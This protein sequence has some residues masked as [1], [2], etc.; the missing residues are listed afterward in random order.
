M[1]EIYGRRFFVDTSA[2]IGVFTPLGLDTR[3]RNFAA[4]MEAAKGSAVDTY[5]ERL[6]TVSVNGRRF[7]LKITI[8]HIIQPLL[9][10]DF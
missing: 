4:L 6:M 1:D 9:I 5:G 3:S 8:A 7:E 2:M 10:A